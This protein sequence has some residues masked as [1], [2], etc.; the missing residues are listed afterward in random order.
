MGFGGLDLGLHELEFGISVV[1]AGL[2]IGALFSHG[3]QI[4][5]IWSKNLLILMML[6][7]IA[8]IPIIGTMGNDA[9]G[10]F[11]VRIPIINNN[12][13]LTRWYSIYIV[14]LIVLAALSLDRLTSRVSADFYLTVLVLVCSLLFLNRNLT[15]YTTPRNGF[16]LYDP[17]PV[18]AEIK[19]MWSGDLPRPITELGPR[20][21]LN[22]DGSKMD[23]TLWTRS[24]Y[25]CYEPLFG[26]SSEMFPAQKL[27]AGPISDQIDGGYIN[28]VDPRCY[29]TST[30]A[31][32][33]GGLFR[34]EDTSD[35]LA[36]AAHRPLRWQKPVWQRVADV[37]TL[38]SL[39]FSAITVLVFSAFNA[40]FFLLH[41]S[42]GW[43]K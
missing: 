10:K 41:L 29:F 12:T 27:H 22:A 2:I 17:A 18:T 30:N 39:V 20:D 37:A 15:Y 8:A 42:D 7:V 26:Y 43:R 36:F 33:A 35:V 3:K 14:P 38:A 21:E 34:S 6:V 25:P 16:Y 1:P 23:A 32:V 28:M 9:W 11:L 13:I 40:F 4:T 24:A 31:C 5:R 19:R